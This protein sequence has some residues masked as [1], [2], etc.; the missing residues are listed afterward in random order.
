MTKSRGI[1]P[2]RHIWTDSELA[3]LRAEYPDQVTSTIAE[4][5]GIPIALVYKKAVNL[6]LRKSSK[7]FA[8]DSSG[9]F[10]KGGKLSVATRF[11]PGQKP[12]NAGTHYTAGGRSA[13]TRFKKGEMSGA[14]Q[15]NWVP[16][17]TY[18]INGDGILDRKITDLGRGP[19][20]W[21]AVHRLVWKE[22][23]GPIPPNHVI[24]FLPGRRTTVLEEI[25]IDAVECISRR[26]LVLRNSIWTKDH[27][28]A[29]LYQLKGQIT[30]QVNRIQK[31]SVQHV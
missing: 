25:T 17:G 12:W 9:R 5:L 20:D 22:A 10:L 11:V 3:T 6:G 30:R 1:L 26:E 13:E 14:A 21:E 19:R 4:K 31:A 27:D 8:T 16:V 2:P 18:R 29:R 15:R 28:V 24:V 7:F 23:N